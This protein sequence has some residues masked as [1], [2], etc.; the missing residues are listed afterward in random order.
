MIKIV[1]KKSHNKKF[2]KIIRKG[3]HRQFL[4]KQNSF[5]PNFVYEI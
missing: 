3:Q 4:Q 1:D 5:F 2:K